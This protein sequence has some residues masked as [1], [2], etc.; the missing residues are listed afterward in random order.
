M[1]WKQRILTLI[2]SGLPA[3]WTKYTNVRFTIRPMRRWMQ[4]QMHPNN[5]CIW[6]W[7]NISRFFF[8]ST[9]S[10]ATAVMNETSQ[11]IRS[12]L[13]VCLFAWQMVHVD[14][15]IVP[16]PWSD[17]SKNPCAN[18]PGGWQLLYWAPLKQ[19]FKIFTVQV[20]SEGATRHRQR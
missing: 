9:I 14:G 8:S 18:M 2:C 19:C 6:I 16:P 11:W 20:T 1:K 3:V 5:N 10:S 17:P 4:Y 15:A 7:I 13:I 12:W